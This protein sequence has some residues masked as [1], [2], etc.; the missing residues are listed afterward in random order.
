[1]NQFKNQLEVAIGAEKILLSP[2]FE[3]IAQM[4]SNVG[5]V[6]YLAWK[7]SQGVRKQAD[8]SLDK[9]SLNTRETIK[10]LPSLSEVTQIIYYNQAE[11]M[12]SLDEIFQKIVS[13]GQFQQVMIQ[14]TIFIGKML[15]GG[16]FDEEQLAEKKDQAKKS[17]KGS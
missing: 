5:S 14:V 8:G 4:E 11:K 3:N 16:S 13:S 1:M 2:T 17:E 12:Y 7:F 9:D 15:T 6:S 10:G